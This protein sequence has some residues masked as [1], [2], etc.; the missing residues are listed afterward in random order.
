MNFEDQT[1]IKRLRHFTRNFKAYIYVI[2]LI[3]DFRITDMTFSPCDIS[4]RIEI[5]VARIKIKDYS[6]Q[7]DLQ[8]SM[9]KYISA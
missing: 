3:I 7:F 4:N 9:F 1:Y 8:N 2:N 5:T 6:I